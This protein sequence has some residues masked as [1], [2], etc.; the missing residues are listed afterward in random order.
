MLR[1]ARI[2]GHGPTFAVTAGA[3]ISP[4]GE[5]DDA[6]AVPLGQL[7]GRIGRA[8][9]DSTWGVEGGI[10]LPWYL[11]GA[12]LD[13]YFEMPRMSKRAMGVGFQVG[14]TPAVFHRVSW[15]LSEGGSEFTLGNRLLVSLADTD[16]GRFWAYDLTAC[17]A[18]PLG[19]RNAVILGYS[20]FFVPGRFDFG[21]GD[22][23]Y[24]VLSDLDL[25]SVGFSWNAR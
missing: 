18:I 5:F 19:P 13:A 20:H 8:A 22:D 3:P 15:Q 21:G 7:E 2:A 1:S 14:V 24:R 23:P 11:P 16:K 4:H 17:W 10:T 9:S 12:T 6:S 25:V